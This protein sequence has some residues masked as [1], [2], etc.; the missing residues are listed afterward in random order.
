[1]PLSVPDLVLLAIIVIAFLLGYYQGAIRQV[2]TLLVWLATFVLA[3]NLRDPFGDFLSRYWSNLPSGYPHMIAFGVLFTVFFV[4]GLIAIQWRYR[5]IVIHSRVTV[6]DELIGG[7]LGAAVA[8]LVI[9]T[10]IIVLDSFYS[11]GGVSGQ[12][13]VAILGQIHRSLN[14]SNVAGT[15]RAQLFPPLLTVLGPLLPPEVTGVVRR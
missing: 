4:I 6:I 9:A 11:R 8:V 2:L 13:D 12:G 5:R 14:D 1:M 3:A 15:I 7:I 10:F